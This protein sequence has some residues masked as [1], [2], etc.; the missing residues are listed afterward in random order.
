[1]RIT[2]DMGFKKVEFSVNDK[3]YVYDESFSGYDAQKVE[4]L[5]KYSLV[6]GENTVII[7][8]VSL[9]ETEETYKGKCTYRSE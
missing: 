9:E 1:M 4:L 8:A 2:H 6:E 5:Y 7:H 3:E